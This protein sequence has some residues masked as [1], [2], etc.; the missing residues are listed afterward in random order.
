MFKRVFLSLVCLVSLW[1]GIVT[2]HTLD[3]MFI[4]ISEPEEHVYR[5]VVTPSSKGDNG[6]TPS[7]VFPAFCQNESLL[8]DYYLLSCTES[9]VGNEVAV[10][11]VIQ[12]LHVNIVV[13][14]LN[15]HGQSSVIE[16]K[17][18]DHFTLT[19]QAQTTEAFSFKTGF[20]HM[21]SGIEHVFLVLMIVLL[22]QTT[23]KLVKAVSLFTASHLLSMLVAPWLYGIISSDAASFAIYLSLVLMTYQSIQYQQKHRVPIYLFI[24]LGMFHGIAMYGAVAETQVAEHSAVELFYFNLGIET[25]QLSLLAVV[26]VIAKVARSFQFSLQ[27]V[28]Q[29]IQLAK[30]SIALLSCYWL[31]DHLFSRL[32]V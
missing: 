30:Y 4:S 25:A 8:P 22:Y 14:Y 9:L 1:P 11:Y 31:T 10:E 23:V 5:V 15:R 26:L 2:A 13:N 17:H 19:E 29:N 12:N 16:T 32:V 6:N 21:L 7:L 28:E 27:D 3:S 24:V 20:V 18:A